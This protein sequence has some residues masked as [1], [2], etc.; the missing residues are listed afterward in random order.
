M[1]IKEFKSIL[2]EKIK[3]SD[4][5]FI[6]PHVGIDFDAIASSIGFSLISKKLA[7]PNYIFI[8]DNQFSIDPG[9]QIILDEYSSKASFINLEKYKKIKGDN[10]LLIS[11][12][13][14]STKLIGCRDYLEDFKDIVALDH[15]NKNEYTVDAST[16]YIPEKISSTSEIMV[17]LLCK[18]G[19]KYDSNIANYLLSGIYLDTAKLSKGIGPKT[20]NIVSKLIEKGASLETVQEYFAE[21]FKSNQR[22]QE[23]VRNTEFMTY[24]FAIAMSTD[25]IRYS[26]EEI[27]K[28][29]DHLLSYKSVDASFAA[30]YTDED[31]ISISARSKGKIDVSEI[32]KTMS[33]GGNTYS[34]ATKINNES[35]EEVKTKL[36]KELKPKYFQNNK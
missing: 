27:A 8:Y 33:G 24:T 20:F 3:K 35:M 10:D 18:F 36:L 9:V 13:T 12:D 25:D 26:K 5:V 17:D 22:I 34:A 30:G 28:A 15:H 7:K 32:M 2:E 6:T 21:D 31:C 23:I 14:C 11:T 1:D 19:I 16:I 4:Q 29:A